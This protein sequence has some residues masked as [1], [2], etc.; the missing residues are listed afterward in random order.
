MIPL[1]EVSADTCRRP[2]FGNHPSHRYSLDHDKPRSPESGH[3]ALLHSEN[4]TGSIACSRPREARSARHQPNDD[5]QQRRGRIH[6]RSRDHPIPTARGRSLL[7]G[8]QLPEGSRGPDRLRSVLVPRAG[9]VDA[10]SAPR[11][12]SPE[13]P[14]DHNADMRPP[15]DAS[16]L[17][18]RHGSSPSRRA[19]SAL[20]NTKHNCP[21]AAMAM[22]AQIRT[23]T[24]RVRFGTVFHHSR[25]IDGPSYRDVTIRRYNTQTDDHGSPVRRT[26]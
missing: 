11:P 26:E 9:R 2:V 7:D 1:I 17:A 15:A 6:R 5:H 13:E 21:K 8:S 3:G 19:S 18:D 14:S 22:N 12:N 4:G 23:E 24:D 16:V 20:G 10:N 25:R